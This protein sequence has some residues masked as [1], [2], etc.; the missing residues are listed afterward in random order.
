MGVFS[1]GIAYI[2]YFRL[3]ANVGPTGAI[4]VTF[5]IP[6]FAMFWSAIVID[7][8][9]TTSMII[10]CSIIL[11]G[12]AMATGLLSLQRAVTIKR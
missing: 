1:T 2:L 4:T 9:L 7:E 6:G 12:T 11:L 5:L 8:K 3:I 10:G